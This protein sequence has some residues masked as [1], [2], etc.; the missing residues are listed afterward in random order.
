MPAVGALAA[1]CARLCLLCCAL[2]PTPTLPFAPPR[3]LA[4]FCAALCSTQHMTAFTA[5]HLA[6]SPGVPLPLW[7]HFF[8]LLLT[9]PQLDDLR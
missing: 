7:L 8:L 6:L 4:C 2:L 1:Q 5:A 3:L 9:D